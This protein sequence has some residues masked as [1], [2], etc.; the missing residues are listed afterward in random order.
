[1]RESLAQVEVELSLVEVSLAREFSSGID[2]RRKVVR[3]R[4]GDELPYDTLVLATGSANDYFGNAE[5]AARTIGIKELG[6]AMR[7]RN[8]V[9]ACLEHASQSSSIDERRVWLTFVIVGGG[10]T[11][12]EY[13]GALAE[14]LDVRR[15]GERE[16][17]QGADDQARDGDG[18]GRD[19]AR[20]Q[21]LGHDV[22]DAISARF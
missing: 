14:L 6:E 9:L 11:G 10:P 4:A 7:L 3:T 1:V 2:W 20:R 16:P 19:A 22:G 12:V 21:P 5:L 17:G 15:G 13:A 18:V 8:H